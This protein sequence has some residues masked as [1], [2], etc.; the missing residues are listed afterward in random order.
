MQNILGIID[1]NGN[2]IVKYNYN[3]FGRLISI[4]GSNTA[5]GSLNPFRY[6]GYYYDDE[7]CMYYCKSRYYN[8]LWCRWLTPDSV[9]YLNPNNINGLN[10]YCYCNNNPVMYSDGDGHM[11]QWAQ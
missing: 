1:N 11:P 5:I 9:D 4:T 10:L 7:T 6:K 8:P 3:A 2:I